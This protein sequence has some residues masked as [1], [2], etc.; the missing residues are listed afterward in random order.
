MKTHRKH[1]LAFASALL[2]VALASLSI[3]KVRALIMGG[4]GNTP[5]H[6]PGWPKGAAAVFNHKA[7]IAYWEGPPF[8]GGQWHAECRAETDKAVA[9][10]NEML[11]DF[12]KIDGKNKSVIIHD[13]MGHSFWLNPNGNEEKKKDARV[14]WSFMVWQKQNWEHQRS[15]PVDIGTP[16]AREGTGEP[17]LQID[18]Y[19]ANIKWEDVKVPEGVTVN[20]QRMSAHGFSIADGHV[21]EGKVLDSETKKPLAARVVFQKNVKQD[22]GS[23]KDVAEKEIST[24]AD[25]KWVSKKTPTDWNRLIVEADGYV[26]RSIGWNN[27]DPEQ[28]R[29]QSYETTLAKPGKVSGKITGEDGKPLEGVSVSL[30]DV[31]SGGGGYG[32][33]H[34]YD[35]TT[36]ANGNFTIE[37]PAGT[38]SV[39]IH[40]PG[41]VRAGLGPKVTIPQTDVALQ[42]KNSA[43]VTFTVEF[44][45]GNKTGYIVN[46]NDEKGGVGTWGGSGNIDKNNQMVFNDFPPGRYTY[47]G[48]PNPGS[49]REKTDPVTIEIKGGDDLKITL[50]AKPPPPPEP[51]KPKKPRPVTGDK[52]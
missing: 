15:L 19:V 31:T 46:F 42:M 52:F 7:R 48:M 40:K 50:A 11:V 1:L 45:A 25:G 49:E 23:Q 26:S 3:N 44:P 36:D 20:D 37:G 30:H 32:S 47:Y 16:D 18:V 14:D 41:Y 43:R 17:P 13:G 27:L 34:G 4:E 5:L 10:F 9:T 51:E 21:L 2:A 12:A 39:W 38:A 8:G 24:D 29:W 28:P 22:D 6:D 35:A 33:A